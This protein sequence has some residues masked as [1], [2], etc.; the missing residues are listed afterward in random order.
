MDGQ[1]LAAVIVALTGLLLVVLGI[2]TAL[3]AEFFFR[4]GVGYGVIGMIFGGL[5]F[6]FSPLLIPDSLDN[7]I[8]VAW[9]N[10][11][12]QWHAYADWVTLIIGV[13][14]GLGAL[15]AWS[16]NYTVD[17]WTGIR[18][19]GGGGSAHQALPITLFLFFGIGI[20]IFS[21][22]RLTLDQSVQKVSSEFSK[23]VK[24]AGDAGLITSEEP[25]GFKIRAKEES[26]D[27]D[28]WAEKSKTT[29]EAANKNVTLEEIKVTAINIISLDR[30]TVT[31]VAVEFDSKKITKV[32]RNGKTQDVPEDFSGRYTTLKWI[33]NEAETKAFMQSWKDMLESRNMV[34]G[35]KKPTTTPMGPTSAATTT[36]GLPLAPSAPAR[37]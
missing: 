20:V 26:I 10:R 15:A 17:F 1:V 11:V 31:H 30:L 25:L 6:W 3:G 36:S 2:L 9:A 22:V 5:M 33:G 28:P 37:P 35:Q 32:T 7:P 8:S 23:I 16:V 21:I 34:L 4:T 29:F 18:H 19:V 12:F 27:L 14:I 24:L 13:I